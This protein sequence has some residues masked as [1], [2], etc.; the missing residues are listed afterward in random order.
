MA[1]VTEQEKV[2]VTGASGFIAGH[3]VKAL[4]DKGWAVRGTVRSVADEAK[5]AHLRALEGADRL[6][7][8]EADLTSD[9]GW[10]EAVAGCSYVLHVAS[11]FP[12]A[13]PQHE[14]ELVRPAVDGTHRVLS[15]CAATNAAVK[16]VVM[17]SSV[18]AVASGHEQSTGKVFTE[19]DWSNAE[20]CEAYQKSK[21][22]AERHAWKF[23]EE[24]PAEKKF[25]LAVINPGFVIGPLMNSVPGTS[26]EVIRRLLSR[27]MPACP[28]LGFSMVDVRDVAEAHILAMIKPGAAGNRYICAGEHLWMRDMAKILDAEFRPRGYKVPTGHLPYA[29]LWLA[30]RFDKTL[31]GTL[32][33]IGRKE[34]VSNAKAKSELGWK[35]R[36]Y[37]ESLVDMG[38]SAIE[39]GLVQ[40]R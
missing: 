33:F 19:A 3:C 5:I 37:R 29:I 8:V 27:D 38:N 36:S 23:V 10:G 16:R 15:A 32:P 14:D 12:A 24:L 13:L 4:L 22:L 1:N 30:A 7:L 2:L 28:Q 34:E 20:K 6:E 39:V 26:A 40:A 25:E 17:T 21:T 31:R 9:D 35:Q 18:A 11:P